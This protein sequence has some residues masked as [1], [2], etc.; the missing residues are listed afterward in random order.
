MI[1]RRKPRPQSESRQSLRLSIRSI[2]RQT[3]LH[4][5]WQWIA[6]AYA[7]LKQRNRFAQ[8]QTYCCFVGHGRSGHSIVGALL[9]AHRDI[10]LS[11]EL[12]A[13][14]YVEM[15]FSRDQVF[16]LVAKVAADQARSKRQKSGREGQ[17]YSYL[18]PGQWQ[19]RAPQPLVIGD[20][21]AAGSVKRLANNPALLA[22]LRSLMAGIDLRFVQ[23]VRN[24]FDTIATMMLRTGRHFDSAYQEYFHNWE[25]V[26]ILRS[27]LR[28]N[29]FLV[30]S[31]EALLADPQAELGRLC[32]FLGVDCDQGY[33]GACGGILYGA[34]SKSRDSIEWMPDQRATIEDHLAGIPELRRYS[35]DS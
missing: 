6:S 31:H 14:K 16:S 30:V 20:S 21:R 13:L 15:R 4:I 35:F 11:D 22:R 23:V 19:G 18:V 8:V 29:E 33:L 17:V 9:D 25:A 2:L 1:H 5:G 7:A 10:I 34:P 24:P 32:S 3:P 12:D 27:R 28:E 26:S